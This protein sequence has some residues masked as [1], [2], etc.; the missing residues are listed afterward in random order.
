[1]QDSNVYRLSFRNRTG[2]SVF[3][4]KVILKKHGT[5]QIESVGA[6]TSESAKVVQIL[7]KHGYANIKNIRTEQ[8]HP[9]S[10]ERRERG[11]Q[12]KMIVLL[13]KSANFDKL[14]ENL[15]RKE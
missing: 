2:Q 12:I 7:V 15:D 10:T 9:D 3:L 14:T 6:A 5:I 11:F 1:M 4:S 13:E 8:F